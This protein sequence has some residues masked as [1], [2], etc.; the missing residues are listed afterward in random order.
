MEN[1]HSPDHDSLNRGHNHPL[2]RE[3]AN[4]ATMRACPEC[5]AKANEFE[6]LVRQAAPL[7]KEMHCSSP[8]YKE[9][10]N[11]D[12]FWKQYIGSGIVA[13]RTLVAESKARSKPTETATQPVDA[14]L[15]STSALS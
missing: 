1:K 4:V 15:S 5:S 11:D 6:E 2:T 13:A 12:C 7:Y 9:R 3:Y 8:F 14:T 10:E